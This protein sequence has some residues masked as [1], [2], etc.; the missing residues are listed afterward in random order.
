M[1]AR[2]AARATSEVG[3]GVNNPVVSAVPP[4]RIPLYASRCWKL[5]RVEMPGEGALGITSLTL[6]GITSLTVWVLVLSHFNKW[7]G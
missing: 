6:F 1:E 5:A 3:S 4:P 7:G 2:A